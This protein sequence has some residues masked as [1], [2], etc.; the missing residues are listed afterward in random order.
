M[1]DM[2]E[3]LVAARGLRPYYARA[4]SALQPVPR[5]GLGTIAVDKHWRLYVD[6]EWFAAQTP[7]HRA[8]LIA[9]HEVEHLLRQHCSLGLPLLAS[10]LAI[11]DDAEPDTLPSDG[12]Y[13]STYGLPDGKTEE[14]YADNLP[15]EKRTTCAGGSGAGAPIADELPEEDSAHPG[16]PGP[17]IEQLLDDVAE[18]VREHV[19]KCGVGSAPAHVVMWADARAAARAPRP[20]VWQAALRLAVQRAVRQAGARSGHDHPSWSRLGHHSRD[21][22]LLASRRS[23]PLRVG[24]IV[25]TSGSMG[26]EGSA[27]LR[28][29]EE[30]VRGIYNNGGNAVWVAAD[31][32]VTHKG[33]KPPKQWH[34]GGGTDMRVAFGAVLAARPDVIIVITDGETPWPDIP[35]RPTVIATTGA[36]GPAWAHTVHVEVEKANGR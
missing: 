13:P 17:V 5:P 16:L 11:N 2:E 25:D 30:V 34:G 23:P 9:S 29:V 1:I 19:R 20:I 3:A 31:A 8:G 4:I 15:Q 22:R 26:C 28:I 33:K 36:K 24:C 12:C 32:A 27:V 18:D 10:D 35:Q 6:P 14:W 21:D 7:R